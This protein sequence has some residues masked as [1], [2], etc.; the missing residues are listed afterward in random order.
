MSRIAF[1]CIMVMQSNH[2][3]M[4]ILVMCQRMNPVLSQLAL[5]KTSKKGVD[6]MGISLEIL[7]SEWGTGNDS[8]GKSK[9]HCTIFRVFSFMNNIR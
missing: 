7:T 4:T 3:T 9:V 2:V 8:L 5:K 1:T 6:T